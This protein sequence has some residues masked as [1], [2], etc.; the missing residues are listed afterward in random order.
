MK[1]LKFCIITL[2]MLLTFAGCSEQQS[3]ETVMSVEEITSAITES[4]SDI[5]ELKQI[6]SGNADFDDYLSKSYLISSE[7][8][9]DGMICYADGAQAH[10]IAVLVMTDNAAAENAETLLQDYITKRAS[11]FE[12]YAPEQADIA[13]GGITVV[14]G[15]YVA[16]LICR[17]TSAAETAFLNCFGENA[18]GSSAEKTVSTSK[19]S[20]EPAAETE[21]TTEK[22]TEKAAEEITDPAVSGEDVYDHDV[23]LQ[24]WKSGDSS[25][26]SETN[27]SIL[28]AAKDVIDKEINDD[29]SDYEKELAIH[30]WIT[31]WSS[32]DY[33]VFDRSSGGFEE[34]SDTPYGVL[35]AREAMC[36]GY[37]AT[38]QLFMDMLDIECI[39]VFG[40]PDSNGIE[41][42]WNMVKLDGEWYCVDAAW[43]D[44][45]GGT[46]GH[47]YFNVTSQYLRDRG[48]H[49]WDESAVPEAEG[50]AYS[51]GNQ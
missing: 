31:D 6:T 17:D 49:H 50:T 24:A 12:G 1:K 35:I 27:L 46:P 37:S 16:L 32:F 3:T 14:N 44:P 39:T 41:H 25:A 9:E 45:I 11:V 42:S 18:N 8:I 26:L 40:T 28:N 15:K 20:T 22:E 47:S 33:G 21:I 10:E 2:F 30:D 38:F 4:Q 43:D 19:S 13:K 23:V 51:Y 5:P 29:M 7:Q 34:G 36:H 48:I